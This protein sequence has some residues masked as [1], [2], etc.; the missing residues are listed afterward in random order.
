[1]LSFDRADLSAGCVVHVF[2]RG[3]DKR[4]LFK[5]SS[6]YDW[7]ISK[8]KKLNIHQRF[9]V[10][11][12]CLMPNHFHYFLKLKTDEK[13]HTFFQRFQLAY[14]KYYNRKYQRTGHVFEGP[15]KSIA[16]NDFK[17]YSFLPMYIHMN[18]VKAGLVSS[19]ENWPHSNY[20]ELINDKCN[21]EV[22]RF[23]VKTYGDI[24]KYREFVNANDNCQLNELT[25][26][27]FE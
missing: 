20:S 27:T 2:N 14:A 24:T 26:V 21:L 6:D 22:I 17:H 25:S 11:A 10:L 19:P 7:F 23:Y 18:P 4:I 3:N 13:I 8:A 5:T 15:F 9:E 16:L 1:M 12:Y